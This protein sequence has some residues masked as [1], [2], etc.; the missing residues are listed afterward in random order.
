MGNQQA[1]TV[2]QIAGQAYTYAR[3]LLLRHRI[4]VPEWH[5]ASERERFEQMEWVSNRIAGAWVDEFP[6]GDEDNP[7][8]LALLDRLIAGRE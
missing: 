5:D 4:R 8:P 1:L 7:L 2:E 3:S 6:P